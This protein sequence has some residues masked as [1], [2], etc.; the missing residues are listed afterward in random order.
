MEIKKTPIQKLR[1]EDDDV[2]D[3]RVYGPDFP[4]TL[5]YRR[6]TSNCK[7]AHVEDIGSI[8]YLS[9]A[10]YKKEVLDYLTTLH[11]QIQSLIHLSLQFFST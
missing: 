11:E 3:I 4:F 10:K 1:W 8:N 7:L 9:K 5:S 2:C 6:S